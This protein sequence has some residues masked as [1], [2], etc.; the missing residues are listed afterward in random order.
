MVSLNS[1]YFGILDTCEWSAK[2]ESQPE[3]PVQRISWGYK[4]RISWIIEQAVQWQAVGILV[5]ETESVSAVRI[6]EEWSID[7]VERTSYH[8]LQPLSS[9]YPTKWTFL[10]KFLTSTKENARLFEFANFH[11][12]RVIVYLCRSLFDHNNMAL[13]YNN[14]KETRCLTMVYHFH[15]IAHSLDSTKALVEKFSY[16]LTIDGSCRTKKNDC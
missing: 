15:L 7:P 11:L 3:L 6:S 4:S 12:L 8:V 14:V 13:Q 5:A 9:I 10:R 2:A 16:L 1:I